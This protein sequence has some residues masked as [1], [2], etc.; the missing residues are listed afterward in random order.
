MSELS[1]WLRNQFLTQSGNQPHVLY[2]T[3]HPSK[4]NIELHMHPNAINVPLKYTTLLFK[5]E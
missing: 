5:P 1:K 4:Q 2:M 3:E